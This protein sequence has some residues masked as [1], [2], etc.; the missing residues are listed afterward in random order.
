MAETRCPFCTTDDPEVTVYSDDLVRGIV[1]MAPIN[2]Y[3][4]MVVPRMHA[5]RLTE[6]PENVAAA[7]IHLAQ[8]IGRAITRTAGAD[9]IC[10]IAEDDLTGQGYNL[11][12]HW[13]LHVIARYRDDAVRFEWGRGEDPGTAVRAEIASTIRSAL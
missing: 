6:L 7:A 12:A 8:R 10:Y 9:G 5:E 3:H 1:S 11:V 13:K 4:V 2:G